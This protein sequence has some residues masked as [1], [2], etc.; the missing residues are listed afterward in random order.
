MMVNSYSFCLSEKV[1]F[2]FYLGKT[3]SLDIGF[4]VGGFFFSTYISFY[5]LSANMISEELTVI[6]ISV[7]FFLYR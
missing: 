4:E 3:I 1:L 7:L 6:L 5:F 2:L